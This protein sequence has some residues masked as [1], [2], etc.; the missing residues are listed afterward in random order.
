MGLEN[1]LTSGQSW[2]P[3]G[4]RFVEIGVTHPS[5]MNILALISEFGLES[6]F[7]SQHSIIS[8]N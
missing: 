5:K 4:E 1:S 8:L 3:K 2:V 7:V 6:I